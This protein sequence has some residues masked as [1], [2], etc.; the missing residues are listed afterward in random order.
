MRM[1]QQY[2]LGL[3]KRPSLGLTIFG[4]KTATIL[5]HS[6]LL[7]V[8]SATPLDRMGS[9]KISPMTIPSPGPHVDAKKM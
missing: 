5:F 4:V 9:G 6:Q 7:A 2:H 1:I 8:L 3:C